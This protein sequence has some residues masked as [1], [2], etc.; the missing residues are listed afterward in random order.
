MIA[1]TTISSIKVNALFLLIKY[2]PAL[3]FLPI[4]ILFYFIK[5]VF[6]G[7]LGISPL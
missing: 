7:V 4:P 2:L 1:T 5:G 3:K 6:A